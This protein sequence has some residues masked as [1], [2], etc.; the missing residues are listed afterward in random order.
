MMV[1]GSVDSVTAEV[2]GC[3]TGRHRRRNC[4]GSGELRSTVEGR[5]RR[6]KDGFYAVR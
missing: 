3:W 6:E 2:I 5:T 1:Y 4:D